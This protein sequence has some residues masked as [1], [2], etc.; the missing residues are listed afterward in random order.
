M[1]C[2]HH[3]DREAVAQCSVCGKTLCRECAELYNPPY[4]ADCAR[5]EA[6][7]LKADTIRLG[8]IGV[9]V[10][11]IPFFIYSADDFDGETFFAALMTGLIFGCVPFG[12][13]ALTAITPRLFLFLPVVGWLIYF[14]LKFTIAACIGIVACPYKIYKTQQVLKAVEEKEVRR[15]DIV[16]RS[17]NE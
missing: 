10:A 3:P 15:M 12:W 6:S 14:F 13:C 9:V 17:E 2:Y 4:C 16:V 8:V 5:K 11:L 1:S 7:E